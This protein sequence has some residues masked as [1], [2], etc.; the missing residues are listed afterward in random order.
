MSEKKI[1]VMLYGVQDGRNKNRAEIVRCDRTDK[2]SFY[3]KGCC[4][5]VTSFLRK[6]CAYGS[7]SVVNGYTSRAKKGIDFNY[8]YRTDELY[9]ALK[10]PL[11]W[12]VALIDDIVVLNLTFAICSKERWNSWEHKWE[13][14]DDY[15]VRECGFST[16]TYSYIPLEELTVDVLNRIIKYKPTAIM[17]G[18]ITDYQK[19]IVPNLLFE[20]S[21]ALPDLYEKLT[22]E[23]PEVK[24]IVPNFVGKFA[25]IHSLPDET[26]LNTNNGKF[27]KRGEYVFCEKYKSAFL[28]F[29]ANTSEVSIKITKDMLV[30]IENNNQVDENTIF[31]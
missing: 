13:E 10:H 17:G 24:D 16:G 6:G 11:D 14:I 3:K 8:R 31:Q 25:Y 1:N 4:L 30:K 15:A 29:N 5:N 9:G 26:V 2:C 18:E 7:V 27:V 28:P 19:T 12:R 23:H 22:A 21:K 20:I